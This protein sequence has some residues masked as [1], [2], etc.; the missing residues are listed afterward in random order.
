M[1]PAP[2]L[3]SAR[4]L[5]LELAARDVC[6]RTVRVPDS[7][8]EGVAKSLCER[9]TADRAGLREVILA[10]RQDEDL[11]AVKSEGAAK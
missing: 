7:M 9:V 8:P 2:R 4:A 10:S 5:Y 11:K 6:L 3:V 1:R